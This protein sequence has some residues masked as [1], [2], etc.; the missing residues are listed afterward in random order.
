MNNLLSVDRCRALSRGECGVESLG[1]VPTGYAD[2]SSVLPVASEDFYDTDHT[3]T[4]PRQDAVSDHYAWLSMPRWTGGIDDAL[5]ATTG[6]IECVDLGSAFPIYAEL[7]RTLSF[8]RARRHGQKILRHTLDVYSPGQELCEA[9]GYP[10]GVLNK[11]LR[12][13]KGNHFEDLT[14]AA[15]QRTIYLLKSD[16]LVQDPELVI[17]S[18]L[19]Y[20][21][22][23]GTSAYHVLRRPSTYEGNRN[24][25]S[26]QLELGMTAVTSLANM[27]VPSSAA[28]EIIEQLREKA[29]SS[30]APT[31]EQLEILRERI[32]AGPFFGFLAVNELSG[33]LAR[34]VAEKG[35][36]RPYRFISI[37]MGNPAEIAHYAEAHLDEQTTSTGLYS[38]AHEALFDSSRH[39][40]ASILDYLVAQADNSKTYIVSVECFPYFF[41]GS[42][43][44]SAEQR[45]AKM[46]DVRLIINEIARVLQPGG[47]FMAI[48]MNFQGNGPFEEASFTTIIEQLLDRGD[49]EI[50]TR[51]YSRRQLL[52]Y[53][54]Q[55]DSRVGDVSPMLKDALGNGQLFRVLEMSKVVGRKSTISSTPDRVAPSP[56]Q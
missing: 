30:V 16:D 17:Q 27:S 44:D 19:L 15:I 2:R 11:A 50:S 38:R 53:I 47:R 21:L 18:H 51:M 5:K 37:D 8:E 20:E 56:M 40:E 31:P 42:P 34:A 6:P 3:S 32:P 1:L 22:L 33:L 25:D 48:P 4:T 29:G 28:L 46:E 49:I 39:I 43:G 10:I 35:L 13:Y 45:T 9:S 24:I 23:V 54:K 41:G 36:I 12:G 52:S 26:V 7:M 14:L 55:A